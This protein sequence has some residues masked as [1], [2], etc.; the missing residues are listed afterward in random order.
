M[1]FL[2]LLRSTWEAA[3]TTI[4][5]ALPALRKRPHGCLLVAADGRVLAV[6]AAAGRPTVRPPWR[7]QVPG[8]A[9]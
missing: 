1:T 3:P 8:R 2:F 7:V 5:D 6:A 9:A 4:E